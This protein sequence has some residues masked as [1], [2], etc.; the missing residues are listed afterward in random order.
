[1]GTHFSAPWD[2][3]V[4]LFTAAFL[5]LFVGLY[6]YT[7][8]F[9]TGALVLTIGLGAAAFAVRGYS[10][11]DG[12]LLVH[13]LGWSTSFDLANLS[14]VE[15]SPGV[16]TGSVR[17]WGIGGLFGYIGYFRNSILGSYRAYA[18]NSANE[19]VLQFGDDTIV[20]TPGNPAAFVDALKAREVQ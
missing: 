9:F 17:T 1:M 20:V 12:H 11:H 3:K 15:M 18:T 5:G 10:I 7:D 6:V 16:T 2:T 19:V 13:R 14:H 8:S 4:K